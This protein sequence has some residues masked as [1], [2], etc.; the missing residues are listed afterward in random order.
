MKMSRRCVVCVIALMALSLGVAGAQ[1]QPAMSPEQAA[2][3]AAW[4]KAMTP[5]PQHA[6]LAKMAGEFTLEVKSTMA[7]GAEPEVSSAH[8]S[9]RMI[10]GGR[11]LE[12]KVNG[13]TMGQEFEGRALT[14]YDNTSGTWFSTWVDS[15]STGIMTSTGEWDQGTGVGTFL[16][17]FNDPMTGQVQKSRTVIHLLE[18]GNEKMEMYMLTDSGEFKSMEI[19]YTRTK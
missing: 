3:M 5:G 13:S 19:L 2:M 10:L 9:R 14:G 1:D 7:P 8:S 16:G 12:E 4:Q 11:Y 17:E 18:G 6:M 15:M